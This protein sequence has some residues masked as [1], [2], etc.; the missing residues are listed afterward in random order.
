MIT[1]LP[2]K[3]NYIKTLTIILVTSKERQVYILLFK[4]NDIREKYKW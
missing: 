1:F 4:Y 2:T 3:I